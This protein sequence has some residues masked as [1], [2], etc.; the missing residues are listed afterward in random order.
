MPLAEYVDYWRC[1]AQELARRP[2][3]FDYI[4]LA[5]ANAQ[6]R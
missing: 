3:G 6:S 4:I 2:P 5:D 1:R